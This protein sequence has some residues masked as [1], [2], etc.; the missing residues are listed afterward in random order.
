[1]NQRRRQTR[2]QEKRDR[3]KMALTA[4]ALIVLWAVIAAS[5]LDVWTEHP[6]EQPI[7]GQIYLASIRNGGEPVW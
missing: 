3:I 1:M 5:A 4:A 7:S 6:G 2:E